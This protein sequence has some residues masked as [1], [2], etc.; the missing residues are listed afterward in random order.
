VHHG[1]AG[2]VGGGEGAHLVAC[3]HSQQAGRPGTSGWAQ[4]PFFLVFGSGF[5]MLCPLVHVVMTPTIKLF[6]C[7]L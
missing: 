6:C 1:G 7:Y 3:T 2:V 5:L 4:L